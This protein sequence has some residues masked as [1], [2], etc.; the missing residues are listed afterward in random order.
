MFA[1]LILWK[2]SSLCGG[3]D[4][5]DNDALVATLS[6][7]KYFSL[8]ISNP[9]VYSSIQKNDEKSAEIIKRDIDQGVGN[10]FELSWFWSL[11]M[12]KLSCILVWCDALTNDEW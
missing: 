3:S 2:Y 7:Q 11:Q 8:L 6:L 1:S 12:R 5:T 4:Y 9:I 10:I